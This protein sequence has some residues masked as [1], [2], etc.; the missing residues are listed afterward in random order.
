MNSLAACTLCAVVCACASAYI[1]DY[2]YKS[3]Y[4]DRARGPVYHTHDSITSKS[5]S[6][7]ICRGTYVLRSEHYVLLVS[8]LSLRACGVSHEFAIS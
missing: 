7:Y 6:S 8:S 3:H 1:V 4:V 5:G 2:G